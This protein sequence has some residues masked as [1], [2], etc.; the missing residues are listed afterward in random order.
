MAILRALLPVPG[1]HHFFTMGASA[2]SNCFFGVM[3][4]IIRGGRPP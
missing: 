3:T 2:D 4:R 1:L